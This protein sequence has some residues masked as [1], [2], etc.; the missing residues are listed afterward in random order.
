[1][2][3]KRNTLPEVSKDGSSNVGLLLER[4]S[5]CESTSSQDFLLDVATQKDAV[6]ECA[7]NRWIADID[8]S[9]TAMSI[10]PLKIR[11]RLVTG[12]GIAAPLEI[13]LSLHHTYGVPWLP[14]SGLKGLAAHYC[15]KVWGAEDS[16]FKKDGSAYK[17]MFGDQEQSGSLVFHD[18][19][20]IPEEKPAFKLDVITVHHQDYYG[21]NAPKPTEFDSPVP[22][23]FLSVSGAFKVAVQCLCNF[24]NE[25]EQRRAKEWAVLGLNLLQESLANWGFGG[26]TNAGY[27]RV[28][29]DEF[30]EQSRK[31]QEKKLEE[32]AFA[33]KKKAEAEAAEKQKAVL[34]ATEFKKV[35]DFALGKVL[36]NGGMKVEV[37]GNALPCKKFASAKVGDMAKVRAVEWPKKRPAPTMCEIIKIL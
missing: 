21:G 1:M 4:F 11:G 5:D 30:A 15:D 19:W 3:S 13:N 14:G 20:W 29:S 37:N 18:G 16:N 24:E 36:V 12:L 26:K 23:Q 28:S 34:A 9:N 8:S 25:V 33:Q 2:S 22:V 35:G 17:V 31:A 10:Q 27:G 6:Y 32:N 7:Y